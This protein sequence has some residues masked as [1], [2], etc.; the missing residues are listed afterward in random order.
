MEEKKKEFKIRN[1]TKKKKFRVY[2]DTI[3]KV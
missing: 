1:P 2:I 3:L